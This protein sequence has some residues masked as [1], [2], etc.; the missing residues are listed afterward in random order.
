M[1]SPEGI[2]WYLDGWGGLA[3]KPLVGLCI[4]PSHAMF[5]VYL[6]VT[7]HVISTMKQI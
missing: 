3:R 2:T 6:H 4:A 1:K 7:N 5:R